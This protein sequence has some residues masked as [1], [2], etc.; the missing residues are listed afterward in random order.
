MVIFRPAPDYYAIPKLDTALLSGLK[1]L[2]QLTN[3]RGHSDLDRHSNIKLIKIK[4]GHGGCDA[5]ND[6]IE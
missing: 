3:F 5:D 2:F 4:F 1:G 6:R